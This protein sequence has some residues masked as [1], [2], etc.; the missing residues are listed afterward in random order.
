MALL[1]FSLDRS[2][3]PFGAASELVV[4]TQPPEQDLD[5]TGLAHEVNSTKHEH[6]GKPLGIGGS[7][8]LG[9]N[10]A[11]TLRKPPAVDMVAERAL[12]HV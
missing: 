8:A 1:Q 11:G 4:K 12:K 10:S 5:F 9:P 3:E 6:F 2:D 7:T